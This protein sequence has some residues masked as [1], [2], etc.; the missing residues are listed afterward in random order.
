MNKIINFIK[1]EKFGVIMFG[2][3]VGLGGSIFYIMT[4]L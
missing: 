4:H 3:M 2:V 1:E